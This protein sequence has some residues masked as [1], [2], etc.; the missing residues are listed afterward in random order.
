MHKS[1]ANK[2]YLWLVLVLITCTGAQALETKA[3]QAYLYC[4]QTGTILFEFNADELM[5]PSSMTKIMTAYLVFEKLVNGEIS[6]DDEFPVSKLAW[7]K[8]GSKMFVEVGSHVRVEDLLRGIIVQSGN[9]ACI[10]V[11]EALSGN[12]GVFAAEMTRKAKELGATNTTFKNS[13]GWPD[14]L[15]LTTAKDLA[16]IAQRLMDKFPD[17]YKNYFS[18]PEFKYNNILQKNRNPLLGKF[19]GADGLKTGS[20]DAGGHGMVASAVQNGQRLTL[21]IN[22]LKSAADRAFEAEMILNWGF[23]NF[24]TPTLFKKGEEVVKANVWLGNKPQVG[25]VVDKDLMVTMP[26]SALKHMKV[27]AIFDEPIDVSRIGQIVGKIVVN[28]PDRQPME[29]PL[30]AM[31]D[32]QSANFFSRLKAAVYYLAWGHNEQPS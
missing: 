13:T 8:G 26:R 5:P 19:P 2:L 18:D 10:V 9:D 28:I 25:L 20:T 15:H 1:L 31:G 32:V 11:A 22:G 23:R 3:K 21:V 7:R 29:V 16:I 24:I 14:P 17:L 30:R 6:L 27:E 12:E 4:S